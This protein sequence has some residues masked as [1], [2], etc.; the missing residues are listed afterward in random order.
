MSESKSQCHSMLSMLSS[1][2]KAS[3]S[4]VRVSN[5]PRVVWV[6]T[7]TLR[8]FRLINILFQVGCEYLLFPNTIPGS[9]DKVTNQSDCLYGKE[10]K[11]SRCQGQKGHD[12]KFYSI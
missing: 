5:T 1:V 9:E 7:E 10:G 12:S 11:T 2:K 3:V 8:T 6:E 4:E